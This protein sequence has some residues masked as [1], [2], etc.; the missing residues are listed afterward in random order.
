MS[1]MADPD[2]GRVPCTPPLTPVQF[3]VAALLSGGHSVEGVAQL[4]HVSI[5]TVKFHVRQAADRVPGDLPPRFRLIAWYRKAPLSVLHMQQPLSSA[6]AL[7]EALRI[8]ML[9]LK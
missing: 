3:K 8:A 7:K 1:A 6:H 4:L 5:S 9:P 2:S